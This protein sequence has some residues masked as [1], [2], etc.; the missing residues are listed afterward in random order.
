M[1][2]FLQDQRF[3]DRNRITRAWRPPTRVWIDCTSCGRRGHPGTGATVIDQ[4]SGERAWTCGDCRLAPEQRE[5]AI[6]RR[7]NLEP[8][9]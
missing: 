9:V 3:I 4:A 1:P 5:R 6:K 2:D 7:L 8:K